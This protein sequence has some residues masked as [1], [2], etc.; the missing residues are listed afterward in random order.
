MDFSLYTLR[1][2]L[3]YA[4]RWLLTFFAMLKELLLANYVGDNFFNY[5][6]SYKIKI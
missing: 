3:K 2:S 1:S 4:L 5:F 6:N